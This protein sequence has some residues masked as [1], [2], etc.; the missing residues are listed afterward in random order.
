MKLKLNKIS[1]AFFINLDRRKDRLD[2]INKNLPFSAERFSAIEAKSLEL[3]DEIKKIFGKNLEKFT[4]AEIACALSHYR[5]WKRLTLD[6]GSDNYLILEDDV[7][8]KEGFTNF[9]NQV[10]SKNI[11]KNYNLIYLGGCQP[12]NKPHYH[13][14]LEKYNDY[15]FNIKRN[16]FFT[17]NDHFWHMNASSYVLS[18]TAASLLC[19]WVEQNG[20]D[21]AL[22]N[23]MQK[24]FNENKLFAV[25]KSIYHLNP[26]MS[27]QLHEENDNTEIDKKSDLRHATEKFNNNN[28][29][30]KT[31]QKLIF[32]QKNLFEQDFI[33]ELFEDFDIVINEDMNVTEQDS[34][35]VYS[36]MYAK[37]INV[38][39][40][41]FRKN[42]NQLRVK[43]KE[44]FEKLKDENCILVHLSDEHCHAEI[45]HYKNFKHVFR[46]YYRK[47][48]AADNVTFIPL[49]YKK[50]F[51]T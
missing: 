36:D 28:N 15:F 12:W 13:K 46:Q 47:D 34:V 27:Y 1:K 45:D 19:Q 14:V 6:K 26:L 40:E 39:P 32:T 21:D 18:K 3:N 38:Y 7:V 8:F 42:L 22:D 30:K 23:F 17:K 35:I 37:N 24:F 20:I 49:G 44:Y 2:H 31:S 9:W 29:N 4:K 16:D 5:L 41:K 51:K 25:P 10:F 50:G 43:Q 11:P 33:C 48:A